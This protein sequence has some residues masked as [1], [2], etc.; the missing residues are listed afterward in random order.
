MEQAVG[1]IGFFGGRC[2]ACSVCGAEVSLQK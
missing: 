1:S 2:C